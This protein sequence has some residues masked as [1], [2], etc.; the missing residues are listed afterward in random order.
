MQHRSWEQSNLSMYYRTIAF[1]TVLLFCG[2]GWAQQ[3]NNDTTFGVNLF[4]PAPGPSNFFSVES[5]ALGDNMKPSVGFVFYYQHRPFVILNCDENNN[6]GDDLGDGSLGTIN[7]VENLMAAD[8]MGSFNFFKRFQVGLAVP[9]YIWQRGDEFFF[10]NDT[11]GNEW[12]VNE[13]HQ[14]N[15]YGTIGDIR[16]HLKVRILGKEKK[17]GPMLSAA[18][19]PAFPISG[20]SGMGDGYSGDGFL[21]V[22]APRIL[23]GYKFGPLRSGISIDV[24]WREKSEILSAQLGHTLRYGGAVG[25]SIVPGVE[26]L[27]E[28]YGQKSLVAENFADMESAPLLF[29]GGGRFRA[30][31]FVF[32]VGGGGGIISGIGVPQFQVIG[33]AAWSP[34]DEAV[35]EEEKTWGTKWDIDGDGIDNDVDECPEQPEDL[36]GFQDE[37]GCPD[38]DNDNDGINDG[39]DSCPDEP[40]DKDDF[41]DDDGCPDLDHDEDGIKE[42]ADKCP[43]VAEDY[44]G[45]E[46]EDGCPEDD[47][48]GDGIK[49]E[50]DYC[51]DLAEDKDGFED[52]DG[53]PDLDNDNDGVPDATDKCPNKPETLNGFKDDDGC[54]DKGRALVIVTEDRIEIKQKIM[55]ETGSSKI[56]GEKSFE[57]LDI[58]GKILAGNT[59]VRVSIEGH[60]D[61]RGKADKNRTLSKDRAESVKVYLKEKGVDEERLETVGWGPDKP[62]ANNKKRHGRKANRRV[63]FIIIKPEKT[64]I[65]PEAAPAEGDKV[66]DE[67]SM[68]FTAG[69]KKDEGEGSMDF[70]IEEEP[71]DESM[72]FTAEEDDGE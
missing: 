10:E 31:D 61:N 5:P 45:F 54:P 46:D 38:L 18:L 66:E 44:D 32:S 51:P 50:D 63:E 69:E 7:V 48:D 28:I 1:I 13:N 56:T 11:M 62:I 58:I 27:A 47:N 33:S 19:I 55:F 65:T 6:C 30:K 64:V 70:T 60:T 16:L 29:I 53:C 49:D 57:V 24:L 26:I 3:P 2:A 4:E 52:E 34:E 23:A 25:Y 43:D 36:D 40:E 14:Y 71:A 42:P 17:D 8:V 15:S 59:A 12:L 35:E 68:D 37:D 22:T 72:D 20:W 21:T 9:V 41:R 67:G 39:Y